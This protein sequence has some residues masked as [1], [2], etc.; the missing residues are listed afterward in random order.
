MLGRRPRRRR[1]GASTAC[2]TVR[3][4]GFIALAAMPRRSPKTSS[5]KIQATEMKLVA[6]H[7][8]SSRRRSSSSR[9]ASVL[10]DD[11]KASILK[12]RGPHGLSEVVYAFTSA[13]NNNGSAF[14]R[15]TM[16]PIRTAARSA[17]RMLTGRFS[18]I[19]VVLAIAGSLARKQPVPVT[20]GTFPTGTPPS[21]ALLGRHRPRRRRLDVLPRPRPRA[22]P[23]AP[24]TLR[25]RD[26][27]DPCSIPRS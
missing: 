25:W 9:P 7:P 11:A 17:S 23:R 15:L 12:S 6:L 18:L 10:L 4:A 2:C 20:A 3:L 27:R 8:G 24:R 21:S 16:N 13:A 26:S 19:V 14:G 1:L 5:T 22:L